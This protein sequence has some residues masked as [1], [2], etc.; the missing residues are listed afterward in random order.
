MNGW[1]AVLTLFGFL[2]LC[3]G[4]DWLRRREERRAA[5][6]AHSERH[7]QFMDEIRRQP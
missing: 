1:I 4:V 3:V 2:V 6:V 7:R 5:Q